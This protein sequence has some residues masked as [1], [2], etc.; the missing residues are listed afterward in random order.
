MKI[1]IA[2]LNATV[3]DFAANAGRILWAYEDAV[4]RRA[5]LVATPELSLTGYPPQ[6]LIFKSRF[7]SRAEEERGPGFENSAALLQRGQ[8]RRCIA[9]TSH[10][11][12]SYSCAAK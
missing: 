7:V 5:E 1:A 4:A 2:Q 3:G 10:A 8:R 12:R 11:Q 6:D 9:L